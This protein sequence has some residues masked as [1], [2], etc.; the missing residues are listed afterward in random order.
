MTI[1]IP[2]LAAAFMLAFARIGTLVMLMPGIGER[3]LP[4]RVRLSIA[5][6]LTLVI[7]PIVRPLL[8]TAAA[9]AAIVGAL[10]GE[11]AIGLVLGFSTRAVMAALQIPSTDGR[12]YDQRLD[13]VRTERELSEL[14]EEIIGR[15]P[16]GTRLLAQRNPVRTGGPMQVSIAYA[17]SRA[18]AYPYPVGHSI[19]HEVFTRRGGLFF[20]I[21]HLLDR[22]THEL[23]GGELQRVA[24]GAALAGRPRLALLDEPTSQLDPVAGDELLG[25][26]RRLNEEWGT[27][28]VLAE[29]RLERCLII[30][31][32]R[33]QEP[34]SGRVDAKVHRI[35][36]GS[37]VSKIRLNNTIESG[38]CEGAV[39]I[40]MGADKAGLKLKPRD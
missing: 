30:I 2:D 37:W 19:R 3:M 14:F 13:D 36:S 9:P 35:S 28:V 21:A 11:I 24:L 22:A 15:V 40:H 6:L 5:L 10:I 27:A 29:H 25:V 39:G 20:G 38:R 34:G 26:L 12:S 33:K 4:A 18:D 32:C 7:L 17:Q 31:S 16:L 23:S 1:P 8:P